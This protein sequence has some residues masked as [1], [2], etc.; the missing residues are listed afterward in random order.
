MVTIS[1]QSFTNTPEQLDGKKYLRCKFA[2]C[3]LIYA[4]GEIPSMDTCTLTNCT[5]QFADAAE[6]T[7]A[8]LRAIYHGM[9]EG[10]KELVDQT[11]ANIKR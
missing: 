7:M 5:W 8:F 2:S 10:G 9:G 6:R 1:D 3:T 4:G 11:F